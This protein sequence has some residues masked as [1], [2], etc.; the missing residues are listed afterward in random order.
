MPAFGIRVQPCLSGRIE[1]WR[2]DGQYTLIISHP[3]AAPACQVLFVDGL[4]LLPRTIV[5]GHLPGILSCGVSWSRDRAQRDERF[6]RPL[7]SS[8][9]QGCKF[10]GVCD[11]PTWT[12]LVPSSRP[13]EPCLQGWSNT[14]QRTFRVC[15]RG[16]TSQLAS[17]KLASTR[18]DPL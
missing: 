18:I 2:G 11:W 4:Y 7:H 15:S 13:T 3:G 9:P 14:H 17:S 5:T 10:E 8:A 12:L 16:H 1:L 6:V